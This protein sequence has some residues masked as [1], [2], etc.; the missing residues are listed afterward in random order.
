MSRGDT[1]CTYGTIQFNTPEGPKDIDIV[2][3]RIKA[4]GGKHDS[5]NTK[6]EIDFILSHP[7]PGI[8]KPLE[9]KYVSNWGIDT[10]PTVLVIVPRMYNTIDSILSGRNS[11]LQQRLFSNIKGVLVDIAEAI[12]FIHDAASQQPGRFYGHRDLSSNYI[13]IDD[14]GHAVIIDYGSL[15]TRTYHQEEVSHMSPEVIGLLSSS[16]HK[17]DSFSFA[18]LMHELYSKKSECG[19]RARET[20]SYAV[21]HGKPLPVL[22]A[23][24]PSHLKKL[25]TK[26]WRRNPAARPSMRQILSV[27]NGTDA[28]TVIQRWWKK[29][30][31]NPYH[32]IGA[33]MVM[34]SY[35][36]LFPESAVLE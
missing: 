19:K 8:I 7:H 10:T 18:I 2:Q 25:L 9:V 36:K 12:T 21:V 28:A 5:D 23:S 30:Y 35:D 20:I 29:I 13:A 11:A 16:D 4:E 34:K 33:K 32:P 1:R 6:S 26:C 3:Y 14:D 27:V 24:M 31:Y 15:L 17:A 22:A